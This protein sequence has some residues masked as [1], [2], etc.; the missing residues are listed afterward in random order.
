MMSNFVDKNCKVF[1]CDGKE[2]T[3]IINDFDGKYIYLNTGKM[4]LIPHRLVSK[5]KEI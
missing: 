1:L 4:C 5:I 2:E 3:G